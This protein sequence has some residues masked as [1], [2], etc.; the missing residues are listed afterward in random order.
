MTTTGRTLSWTELTTWHL[1]RWYDADGV[2]LYIGITADA[3]HRAVGHRRYS[4]WH[5]WAARVQVEDGF[6]GT[7]GEAEEMERSA[8]IAEQPAFNRRWIER[9]PRNATDY[10]RAHGLRPRDFASKLY[11]RWS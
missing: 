10:L 11:P 8:V 1:Y 7:R 4:W 9:A 2:L 3:D 6:V 5:R